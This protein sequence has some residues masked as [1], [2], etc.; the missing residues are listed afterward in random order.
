M[1]A[2]LVCP[3][4]P[5][6]MATREVIFRRWIAERCPI[7]V[8]DAMIE[9]INSIL[10]GDGRVIS[11]VVNH[12]QHAAANV[13]AGC[14]QWTNCGV[15]VANCLRA[16]KPVATLSV[17]EMAVCE[18]FQ[19]PPDTLR[20]GSQTRAVSQ[21]RM[22]A[23]YLSRQLTSSAYAEIAR[24]FGGKSHS[25]A[26]SAEKNV[27]SWLEQR[28]IDRSRSCGDVCP[29]S[30]RPSRKPASQRLSIGDSKRS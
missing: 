5:L 30:H 6:D 10:S 18:T 23:M 11:G 26:I 22:L 17:I 27:K 25:T 4:Q 19:L 16:S 15:S 2:G 9:Q 20:G 13:R 8:P 14:R 12:D 1:A 7:A 3:I 28:Q 29:R 21:P 24:H